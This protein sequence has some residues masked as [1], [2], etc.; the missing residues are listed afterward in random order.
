FATGQRQN[1]G[2]YVHVEPI[3]GEFVDNTLPKDNGGNLYKKVRPD[4]D[5]AYRNGN[6]QQYPDDGWSKST[7]SAAADWTDLDEFL[8]VM[9]QAT[10]DP[11]YIDQVEV[12]ADLDQWMDWFATMTLLANGETNPSS[13]TDDDYSIYRGEIDP[14][15]ILVPHDLDTILGFGDE[16]AISDPEST[17]FDMIEPGVRGD[18]LNPLVPLFNNTQI[19][20]RYFESLRRLAQTSFAKPRFDELLVNHLSGWVP[21][22]E[23]DAMISWMDQRRAFVTAQ[24][25]IELGPPP[26]LDP[27]TT[28]ATLDSAHGN[29]MIHEVLAAGS[30]DAIEL[31][32]AGPGVATLDGMTLSDEPSQPDLFTIPPGTT[33][34]AGDYISFD[35]T[36]LGFTIDTD[37]ETITLFAP[38]SDGGAVLESIS[39][40]L[41]IP[42][43]SI[44][45]SGPGS[46]TWA[47][48]PPTIGSANAAA[49]PLGSPATLRINEWLAQPDTRFKRDYI[50]LYNPAA[51]PVALGGLTITDDVNNDLS[52]FQLPPLSFI[53]ADGFSVFHPVG[54]DAVPG[55]WDELPFRLSQDLDWI[56]VLGSNGVLVD[57]V[58]LL[59]QT[60]D[61]AQ[62]RAPDGA[63]DYAYFSF[64]TPGLRN[65]QQ[66]TQ[67]ADLVDWDATWKFDDSD[68]DLG[69]AW[70]DPSYNDSAWQSGQAALGVESDP[71][72]IALVTPLAFQPPATHYFRHQFNFTGS[73]A[74]TTLD[75]S[76]LVDDGGIVYLNGTEIARLRLPA[77]VNH[78][79]FANTFVEAI[80]EGPFAVPDGLLLS[81]ANTIA[82]E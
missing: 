59:Q 52:P 53:A 18:I 73:P 46:D 60:P 58:H 42:G 31:F 27:P 17:L 4:V 24:A 51:D 44:G 28:T 16:S 66:T 54:S 33:L 81:G 48:M 35:S 10:S 57:Q 75:L 8:R 78:D 9:N 47:L 38:A 30:P 41:Q 64:A 34:A 61:V 13:G 21:Q 56:T 39:F 15:I 6:F 11:D 7:N 70:R 67:V 82:V 29:L 40:G 71:L 74:N 79:T 1:Y 77:Q 5:W 14:R 37:G 2:S 26:P 62:G 12:V 72:P 22:A 3:G 69:T 80:I 23:I 65:P 55:E 49:T 32:N 63:A 20:T 19:R 25:N 45:R 43:F 76:T 36:Q 68:T 50:E